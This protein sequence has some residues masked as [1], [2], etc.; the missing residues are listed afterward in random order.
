MRRVSK[1]F[2]VLLFLCLGIIMA[3][4]EYFMFLSIKT[5]S[6]FSSDAAIED[7]IQTIKEVLNH[8]S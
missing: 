7:K 6:V 1:I 5:V 4:E 2:I 3:I 8:V